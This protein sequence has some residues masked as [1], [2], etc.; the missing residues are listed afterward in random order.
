VP[1]QVHAHYFGPTY[2]KTFNDTSLLS[3]MTPDFDLGVL[4]P[5]T[6]QVEPFGNLSNGGAPN[7]GATL[8]PT[9]D[10]LMIQVSHVRN[11]AG[12]ADS[13]DASKTVYLVSQPT[14]KI[15]LPGGHSVFRILQSRFNQSHHIVAEVEFRSPNS[16]IY[17]LPGREASNTWAVG[18]NIK[19]GNAQ[20]DGQAD[21]AFG[22]TCRFKNGGEVN[23][24][25]TDAMPNQ[26]PTQVK[27]E[28]YDQ[29]AFKLRFE[30]HRTVDSSGVE[31][32]TG[33]GELTIGDQPPLSG[34]IWPLPDLI[35]AAQNPTSLSAIG[36]AVVNLGSASGSD[37][38]ATVSVLITAFRIIIW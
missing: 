11:A 21:N 37:I 33:L 29:T 24:G 14:R 27:Y 35:S 16:S 5:E 25:Y 28:V 31:T 36:F 23:L 22:P 19:N 3:A 13:G 8:Q 18:L 4:N 38:D 9:P 10:G 30:M 12:R 26:P 1:E 6:G 20:D 2:G 32:D 15:E 17:G 34:K 7:S